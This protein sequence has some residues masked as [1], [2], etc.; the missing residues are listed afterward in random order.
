M[1]LLEWSPRQSRPRC[2]AAAF[3][4]AAVVL[5]GCAVVLSGLAP[6][7]TILM[8]GPFQSGK[9]MVLLV[10][11]AF[12]ALGLAVV[13]PV[14]ILCLRR[15]K[16]WGDLLA[17]ALWIPALPCAGI[18]LL[19]TSLAYGAEP[20]AHRFTVEGREYLLTSNLGFLM[21]TDQT[22]LDLYE[23]QGRLYRRTGR[24]LE[25]ADTGAF[26]RE[27]FTIEGRGEASLVYRGSSGEMERVTLP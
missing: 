27:G 5:G 10:A 9:V 1:R 6:D 3:G 25:T 11:S 15:G 26:D 4:I 19:V 2:W 23:K 24:N 8:L 18:A 20:D 12:L 16:W 17:V 14:T 7:N 22:Y 13:M 21:A